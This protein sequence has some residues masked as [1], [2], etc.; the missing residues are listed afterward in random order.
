VARKKI[1]VADDE[2]N[3]RLLV[4]NMLGKDYEVLGAGDGREA[5][6][7]ALQ[8]K[9]DLILMDIL[10]PRMDGYTAC[11]K[12]KN[13]PLTKDIPVVMLS[14]IGHELNM[15]LARQM[16]ASDYITKPFQPA[17]LRNTVARFL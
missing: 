5:V 9:P 15:E 6:S 1:L 11:N 10:M 7:M 14:A 2:E 17:D 3:I 16:G 4:G 13:D 8:Q 12:I